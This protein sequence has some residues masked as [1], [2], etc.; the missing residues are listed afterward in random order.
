MSEE[1]EFQVPDSRLEGM[2]RY[3]PIKLNGRRPA[4]DWESELLLTPTKQ[5]KA[6]LANAIMALRTAPEW[7]G[8]LAYDEFKLTTVALK[9]PPWRKGED[10]SWEEQQWGDRDDTLTA[11]WLQ[12]HGICVNVQVAA[13]A[14]E[15]VAKDA[16]FHPIRDYLH[17]QEW[18]GTKRVKQ[19]AETYLGAEASDYHHAVSRILFVAAVARIM[20]PGCKH[21]HIPVLE[22]AQG[23]GKSTAISMLFGKWF[24]DDLADLGTKDAAMQ[25]RAAWGIE[26]AE[27]AA[28]Q[29]G[30]M[31][32]IKSFITRQ[33]D[34][35]RP[36]Y[37]R[38]VIEV[39]RQSVFIGTTN[40]EDYLKDETGGRRFLPISCGDIDREAIKRDRDQ[41]WAEAVTLFE[42]GEPW[43]L[44][45]ADMAEAGEK[46]ADR[47][48][49]DPWQ[50]AIAQ[51]IEGRADV[52]VSEVLT[53]ALN[54]IEASR[55][56]QAHQNRAVRC[57]KA[58]GW[59]RF[60]GPRPQREWRYRREE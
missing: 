35:F 37:G 42:A 58:L 54:L 29:R 45:E 48:Q 23:K 60:K 14:V 31:E 52:S 41:L 11:D 38:R 51:Y 21:D 13:S 6:V 27:L 49:D 30:E 46:Q 15:A 28:M 9:P 53:E 10:N 19:F 18:D 43:W 20:R 3:A 57:L 24:S 56:T 59:S 39:P 12:H 44:T 34:R 8:V 17:A 2:I 7:Q 16:T 26:I 5:P 50:A 1:R 47:Y 33:V 32:K 36:S 25:V 40:A 4:R 55:V 22:G